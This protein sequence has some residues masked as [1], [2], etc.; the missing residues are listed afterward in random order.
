M[1]SSILQI[2]AMITMAIDHVSYVYTYGDAHTTF[3]NYIGRIAFPIFCFQI[4]LGYKK[5][6]N[7]GKYILKLII[8]AGVTQIPYILF[9]KNVVIQSE[10]GL[11]VVFTLIFGLLAI[12]IYDFTIENKK[13]KLNSE[14]TFGEKYANLSIPKI[15]GLFTIKIIGISLILYIVNLLDM[16]YGIKGIVLILG[17]YILYPFDSENKQNNLLKSIKIFA[18]LGLAFAFAYLEAEP[19]FKVVMLGYNQYMDEFIGLTA[20]VI[21]GCMIPF[22]YNGNKGRKLKI[23]GYIFYPLQFII[24]ILINML[25]H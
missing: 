14:L 6:K 8:V 7:L 21:I 16:E 1:P 3:L 15:I 17:F 20:G 25:V 24:V 19:Y 18:F 11:N 12:L 10:I 2:I 9:F 4:A 22:L 13:I 5:T 23:F